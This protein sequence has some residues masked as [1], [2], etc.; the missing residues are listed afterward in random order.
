VDSYPDRRSL[1]VALDDLQ[2]YEEPFLDNLLAKPKKSLL[3]AEKVV[4]GFMPPDQKVPLHIRIDTLPPVTAKVKTR[5]LRASHLGKFVA[6]EGLVRKATE[7]RPKLTDAYFECRRCHAIIREPQE[8]LMHFREPMECYKSDP[9]KYVGEPGCGKPS[10][11]TQFK[12]LTDR[13]HFVDTQEIE[14]QELPE[15]LR[16]G[17]QP[18]RITIYLDDDLAGEVNP[19]DRVTFNGILMS[20][21]KGTQQKKTNYFD[22]HIDGISVETENIDFEELDITD[23]DKE[24]IRSLAA[25]EEIYGRLRD[26]IAPT[27]YGMTTE[28][29]TLALQLFGG[30]TKSMP[31]RTH[32]RGDI[33]VLMVGDPG[34]AKSQLLRYMKDVS[35][36]GMY[37]S[38]KAATSAG[39]TAAATQENT[40]YG[41][42]RWKLEAG[43]LVLADKGLCCID[44]IDKMSKED[45]SSMHEAMEQQRISVA[46]AGINA[47][48]QCRCAILAA[49]NP[50]F[51][52]FEEYQSVADQI[53]L[54]PTLMSRFDVIFMVRDKPDAVQDAALAEHVLK[55]HLGGEMKMHREKLEDD[56]YSEDEVDESLRRNQPDI[57]ADLLRK[58]VAYSRRECYPVIT[59][60]ALGE[61]KTYYV[62]LRGKYE[63]QDDVSSVPITARQLEAM[64]RLA[65]ASARVRLDNSVQVED[66]RRA[67]SIMNYYLE[68]VAQDGGMMDIDTI[69]TGISS[70]QRQVIP[71]I[72]QIIREKTGET[73]RSVDKEDVMQ[74]AEGRNISREKVDETIKKLHTQGRI[75]KP[76]SNEEKYRVASA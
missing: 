7:V 6:V 29:E 35:P 67:I 4:K 53:D 40:A 21:Q 57:D 15:D 12:L 1:V 44:E 48:L 24:I 13:S 2:H 59:K 28:K 52:R 32:V 50:K 63:G 9:M 41:Q 65:E 16:G 45:R 23:E 60:E 22:I 74:E 5:D 55:S 73:G 51:G 66:A 69:T 20:R 34:T 10:G 36:R 19:G 8:D 38:G 46:K 62:N 43:A 70:S 64:V 39:L 54:P 47:T 25:D 14:I 56:M 33:H 61:L 68:R 31:D 27:I 37:A 76:K 3:I 30:V 72:L 42:S 11:Q 18:Q 26:S 49:A 71:I 17:E 75:F 58:Y